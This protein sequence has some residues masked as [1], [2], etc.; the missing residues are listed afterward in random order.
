ML[1][2]VFRMTNK[3]LEDP[4]ALKKSIVSAQNGI[5]I[6]DPEVGINNI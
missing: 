6:Y 1:E 2:N 4:E 5:K 3:N